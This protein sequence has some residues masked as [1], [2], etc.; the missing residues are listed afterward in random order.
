M[1]LSQDRLNR[2]QRTLK[3]AFGG[4]LLSTAIVAVTTLTDTLK[5]EFGAEVWWPVFTTIGTGLVAYLMNRRDQK[6]D[7]E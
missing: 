7:T 1:K 6:K 2:V 5:V 4:L 3:Q